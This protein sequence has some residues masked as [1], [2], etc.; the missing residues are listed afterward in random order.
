MLVL[1]L[2]WLAPA[3]AAAEA[4]SASARTA[5]SANA[6][7]RPDLAVDGAC[8]EMGWGGSLRCGDDCDEDGMGGVAAGRFWFSVV[9]LVAVP[10]V[11]C[12]VG[13][14]QG[15]KRSEA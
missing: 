11:L 6:T 2:A 8:G 13:L 15:V 9:F 4:G 14:E 1:G 12:C 7:A 5:A 3:A 10:V